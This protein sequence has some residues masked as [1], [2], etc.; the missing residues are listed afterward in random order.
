MPTI[1][2]LHREL[3][4]DTDLATA[5]EFMSS[6]KNLDAITP[7]DLSF[8]TV[9]EVPDKMFNGMLIEYNV[10]IP[11]L[12]KQKWLSE[13]NHVRQQHSFVDIQLIGP[14]KIWHHYH[15]ITEVEG[16]IRFVDHVNYVM[17][18][19]PLGSIAH[20]L[21]VKKQLKHIFDHREKVTPGLFKKL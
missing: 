7:D 4:I 10:G 8:E 17:P 19:G 21:Y 11:F 13:L 3:I 16:G 6:P 1:H 5:W 2:K 9:S 14:Y 20:G 15:E 18:F 12:G